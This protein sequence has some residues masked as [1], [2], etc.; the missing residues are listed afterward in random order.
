MISVNLRNGVN[1]EWN[2]DEYT[3]YKYDGKVFAVIK[4]NKWVGIYNINVVENIYV[5]VDV[6][7]S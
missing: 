5:D 7:E 3:E 1:D 4:D 6:E 2:D